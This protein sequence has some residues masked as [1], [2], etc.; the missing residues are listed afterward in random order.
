MHACMHT[1]YMHT[2]MHAYIDAY[3]HACTHARIRAYVHAYMH[4][5]INAHTH[6][7]ICIRTCIYASMHSM[8]AC[9]LA[10]VQFC[11][12]THASRQ[13]RESMLPVNRLCVL[14]YPCFSL[15][16]AES[17]LSPPGPEFQ[18]WPS[19][20]V[21]DWQCF[22][23]KAGIFQDTEYDNIVIGGAG[24]HD[25]I[26]LVFFQTNVSLATFVPSPALGPRGAHENAAL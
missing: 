7:R 20:S 10:D 12:N 16:V 24:G 2:C 6:I 1:S 18:C 23:P 13:M 9:M 17:S 25:E 3:I 14:T 21:I 19:I 22:R 26:G 4:A 5:R 8:R 15:R 11:R